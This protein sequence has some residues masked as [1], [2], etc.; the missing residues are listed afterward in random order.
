MKPAGIVRQQV[1]VLFDDMFDVMFRQVWARSKTIKP[2][3]VTRVLWNSVAL[4]EGVG[5]RA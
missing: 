5:L 4:N 3:R 1:P 2:I